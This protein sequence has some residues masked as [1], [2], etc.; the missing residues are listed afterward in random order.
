MIRSGSCS[1]AIWQGGYN[2]SDFPGC[3]GSNRGTELQSPSAP[4]R[5]LPAPEPVYLRAESGA[6]KPA[7]DLCRDGGDLAVPVGCPA[8]VWAVFAS[9]LEAGLRARD[10]DLDLAHERRVLLNLASGLEVHLL[11][12]FAEMR[13][14][15]QFRPPNSRHRAA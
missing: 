3:D 5:S 10:E 2:F 11:G 9:G 15:L 14:A 6:W 12:G 13:I 1:A 4:W 7:F 8:R